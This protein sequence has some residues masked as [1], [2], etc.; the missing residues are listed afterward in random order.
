MKL[1]GD[2][3]SCAAS[4]ALIALDPTHLAAAF[5]RRQTDFEP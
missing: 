4:G 5:P 1:H 3:R 2:F